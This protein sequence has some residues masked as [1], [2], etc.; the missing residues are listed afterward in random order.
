M[1]A[2]VSRRL[3][4]CAHFAGVADFE[5][6]TNEASRYSQPTL[7]E[8]FDPR[9]WLQEQG[10]DPDGDLCALFQND[11]DYGYDSDDSDFE[12]LHTIMHLACIADELRVCRWLFAHGAAPT[13]HTKDSVGRTPI[14]IACDYGY[15]D[16][17]TWLFEVG[18]DILSVDNAGWTTMHIACAS[19]S[20]DVAKWLFEVGAANDIQPN[21][22]EDSG[23]IRIGFSPLCSASSFFCDG[24][25]YFQTMLW[26]VLQGAANDARGHFDAAILERD[27]NASGHFD[28]A[29]PKTYSGLSKEEAYGQKDG[30]Q[31][32]LLKSLQAI[33]YQHSTFTRLVLPATQPSNASPPRPTVPPTW[34][35]RVLLLLQSTTAVALDTYAALFARCGYVQHHMAPGSPLSLL[36][37]HEGT[38][39][40]L[41]A[42]FVGV[43]RGRQLRTA[44]EASA[45]LAALIPGEAPQIKHMVRHNS[46]QAFMH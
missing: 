26:L 29:I 20:L 11:E 13:I 3:S 42:D 6:L 25:Y 23:A 30:I 32:T 9:A 27:L 1:G 15:L 19:G 37:G 14:Q 21:E 36:C 40:R 10:F 46:A 22:R 12:N 33:V 41:I 44:R 34:H 28:A 45:A 24:P 8:D 4:P 39:L 31:L 17:A 18:A 38:L 16:I 7:L 43:V 2:F 35:G 5:E